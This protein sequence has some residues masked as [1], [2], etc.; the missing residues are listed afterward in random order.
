MAVGP[1]TATVANVA[2]LGIRTLQTGHL[3]S[4]VRANLDHDIDYWCEVLLPAEI[5]IHLGS[6][7]PHTHRVPLTTSPGQHAPVLH[8]GPRD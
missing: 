4:S 5:E 6:P 2:S 8:G 7:A 1:A 3:A